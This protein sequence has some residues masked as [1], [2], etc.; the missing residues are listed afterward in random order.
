MMK[1][2]SKSFVFLKNLKEISLKCK[3]MIKTANRYLEDEGCKAMFNYAK[4]LSNL[5][6]LDLYSIIILI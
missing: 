5:E 3:K 1:V 2:I 4:H 6:K